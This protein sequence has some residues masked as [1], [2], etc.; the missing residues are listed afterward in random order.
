MAGNPLHPLQGRVECGDTSISIYTDM[1][2]TEN[3]GL[4]LL[5][6]LYFFYTTLSICT[7]MIYTLAVN[8][9]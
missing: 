1:Y 8:T 7:I 4:Y 2:T 6:Y 3:S 5:F 9:P